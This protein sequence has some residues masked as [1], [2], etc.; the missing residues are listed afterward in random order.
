ML[1]IIPIIL[2][3][4]GVFLV[5]ILLQAIHFSLID[6]EKENKQNKS[7]NYFCEPLIRI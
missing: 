5:Y 1:I 4:L 2:P 3:I 7:S 6:D